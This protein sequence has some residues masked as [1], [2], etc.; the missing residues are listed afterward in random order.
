MKTRKVEST[1]KNNKPYFFFLFSYSERSEQAKENSFC[2]SQPP[3]HPPHYLLRR[4]DRRFITLANL[5][6][7][8]D[9][10]D[11]LEEPKL[12]QCPFIGVH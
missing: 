5:L 12:I 3:F 7:L 10:G 1:K 2:L 4:V 9:L 8:E 11:L 6:L